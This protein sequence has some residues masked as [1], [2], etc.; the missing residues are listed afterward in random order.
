MILNA[1]DSEHVLVYH[2]TLSRFLL[3]LFLHTI[4]I[5]PKCTNI[6]AVFCPTVVFLLTKLQVPN[7]AAK[8][9]L[10]L[11]FLLDRKQ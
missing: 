4:P 10:G 9:E 6:G 3:M 8:L 5:F 2:V 11:Q 7:L 1:V